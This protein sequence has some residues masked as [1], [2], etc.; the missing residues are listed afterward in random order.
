MPF[1]VP[2]SLVLLSVCSLIVLPS[3][4]KLVK[5]RRFYS[6]HQMD[7]PSVR[8]CYL[9]AEWARTSSSDDLSSTN[10]HDYLRDHMVDHLHNHMLGHVTCWRSLLLH[11][12]PFLCGSVL[13]AHCPSHILVVILVLFAPFFKLF[14][15]VLR[16]VAIVVVGFELSV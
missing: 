8:S 7:S 1:P 15:V 10:R 3:G 4:V 16:V 2:V 5:R 6:H 9:I 12:P 11:V 14:F 13:V